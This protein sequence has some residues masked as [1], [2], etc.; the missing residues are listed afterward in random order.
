MKKEL[1]FGIYHQVMNVVEDAY[2]ETPAL[3][4]DDEYNIFVGGILDKIMNLS[5]NVSFMELSNC[6]FGIRNKYDIYSI[7]FSIFNSIL[8]IISEYSNEL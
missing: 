8:D 3:H 2:E 4:E 7:G 6:V 1:I 5:D